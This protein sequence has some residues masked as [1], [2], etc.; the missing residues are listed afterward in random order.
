W[1]VV[2]FM[3]FAILQIFAIN[4][5]DLYSSGVTLQALG[6]RVKRYVAVVIDCVIVLGFTIFAVLSTSFSSYLH[7]FVDVV[8][9]WIAPWAAIY[10]VDWAL[11]RFKYLPQHLQRTGRDSFYYRRGG[12]FWPAVVAQL[13]GMFAAISALSATFPLPTWLNEVTYATR[14]SYGYGGDFSIY[15]GMGVAALV[16]LVLAGV[17]V[18][19]EADRQDELLAASPAE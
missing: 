1:F 13:V 3:I 6:V 7:D 11:R 14:D 15:L 10:L 16:Y 17:M 2:L 19:K 8:I 18:R 4:G 12:F 9:V 5:L